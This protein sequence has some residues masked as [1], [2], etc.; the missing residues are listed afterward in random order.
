MSDSIDE[1]RKYRVVIQ[2]S[3]TVLT[4]EA[5]YSLTEEEDI[6]TIKE[7]WGDRLVSITRLDEEAPCQD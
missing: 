6:A 1:I 3:M 7:R 4:G 2:Q 5:S